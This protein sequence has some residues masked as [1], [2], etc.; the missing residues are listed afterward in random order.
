[1]GEPNTCRATRGKRWSRLYV[2]LRRVR[3]WGCYC[4]CHMVFAIPITRSKTLQNLID[5]QLTDPDYKTSNSLP[6]TSWKAPPWPAPASLSNHE[7]SRSCPLHSMGHFFVSLA[8]AKLI[9]ASQSFT[10][11]CLS[12][13]QIL[14]R[15]AL[16]Q[17]SGLSLNYTSSE[18]PAQSPPKHAHPALSQCH[19]WSHH[20]FY[21]LHK[22]HNYLI[23]LCL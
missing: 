17:H 20:P 4:K 6:A 1:M 22:T 3:G 16:R 9:F 2:Q 13:D 5:C 23:L 19:S 18:K 11:W 15:L 8:E 7:S 14:A 21:F 12:H 10:C